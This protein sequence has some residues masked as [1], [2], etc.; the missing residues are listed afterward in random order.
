MSSSFNSF[1]EQH[2]EM[3]QVLTQKVPSVGS[4][5][6]ATARIWKHT[7]GDLDISEIQVWNQKATKAREGNK[8]YFWD[9]STESKVQ[10]PIQPYCLTVSY[11]PGHRLTGSCCLPSSGVRFRMPSWGGACALLSTA[12]YTPRCGETR[13]PAGSPV[14]PFPT[15]TE[16]Q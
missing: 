7:R 2:F 8:R 1:E 11:L 5:C 9:F 15:G 14:E 12:G 13:L 3:T 4:S 6:R 10:L 16:M